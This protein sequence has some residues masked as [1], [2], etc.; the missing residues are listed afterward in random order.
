[1][2]SRSGEAGC[3]LLRLL[4]HSCI[5]LTCHR[6]AQS[7][8]QRQIISTKFTTGFACEYHGGL[9]AA[10]ST[11]S[12]NSSAS[13]PLIAATVICHTRSTHTVTTVC[14]ILH[15]FTIHKFQIQTKGKQTHRL[16]IL[17]YVS[18]SLVNGADLARK[19][20]TV[21]THL[22]YYRDWGA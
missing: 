20:S 19:T 4:L 6:N 10:C 13:G 9:V 17:K 18:S 16:V 8:S 11:F 5:M 14:T 1:M 7:D 2:S 21:Y 12:R 22:H 15:S 3:E